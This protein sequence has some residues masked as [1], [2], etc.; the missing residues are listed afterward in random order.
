MFTKLFSNTHSFTSFYKFYKK[1][2]K[3][4]I[5]HTYTEKKTALCISQ[6]GKGMDNK[7]L[8]LVLF[9]KKMPANLL[10]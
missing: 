4:T 9:V 3:Q 7:V 2:G 1:A 6:I 5:I 8:F 10:I